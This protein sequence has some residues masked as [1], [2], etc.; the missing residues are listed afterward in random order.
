[1]IWVR[2]ENRSF[3]YYSSPPRREHTWHIKHRRGG[4]LCRI[5][6]VVDHETAADSPPEGARQCLACIQKNARH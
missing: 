6:I 4:A 2:A 5:T 1:M 3:N